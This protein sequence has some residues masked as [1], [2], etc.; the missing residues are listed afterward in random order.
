MVLE[1]RSELRADQPANHGVRE[2]SAQGRE[3]R[4]GQDD[5]TERAGFY[6][7]DVRQTLWHSHLIVDE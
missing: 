5:V 1:K 6:Y 7:Q 2:T 3:G 4:Q